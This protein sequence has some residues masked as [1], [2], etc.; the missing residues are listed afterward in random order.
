MRGV[1]PNRG[2]KSIAARVYTDH[3]ALQW[4]A[5][6]RRWNEHLDMV[7]M[8]QLLYLLLVLLLVLFSLLV[9]LILGV[10]WCGRDGHPDRVVAMKVPSPS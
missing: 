9:M 10:L 1:K 2:Q 3:V 5:C 8:K 7:P 6:Q 4:F